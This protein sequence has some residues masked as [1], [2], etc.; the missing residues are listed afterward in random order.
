[1]KYL[2]ALSGLLAL[3]STAV[4]DQPR[5]SYDGYKVVRVPVGTDASKVTEIV[6]KLKL[7]TWGGAPRAGRY[8]D[9]VIPPQQ[10]AAFDSETAGME[11]I[12][13]HEDLGASIE[14]ESTYSLYS[15]MSPLSKSVLSERC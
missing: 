3:A 6:T 14:R 12:I 1:M 15:G 4:I 11:V 2:A 10:I 8:A 9:I 13:M 5:V 7:K